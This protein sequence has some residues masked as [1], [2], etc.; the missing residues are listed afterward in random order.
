[1]TIDACYYVQSIQLDKG[2]KTKSPN[3][4]WCP[5]KFPKWRPNVVEKFAGFFPILP[6][7]KYTNYLFYILWLFGLIIVSV[8]WTLLSAE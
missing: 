4:F 6:E 1:M 2:F 7:E 3:F 5:L 8:L